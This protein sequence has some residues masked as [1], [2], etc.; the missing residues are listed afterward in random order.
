MTYRYLPHTSDIRVAI[1]GS[2]MA[3]V[4]TEA[5]RL[6]RE[7]LVGQ[8]PVRAEQ[9]R[10]IDVGAEEPA[11]LLLRFFR[12]CLY[13]FAVERFVPAAL[14]LAHLSERAICGTIHGESFDPVRHDTQPEVKAVTRHHLSLTCRS[15]GWR[16]EVVF[17]L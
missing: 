1:T 10:S 15:N 9:A 13:L 2:D 12:E 14:D 11:E 5:T 3:E 16:A 8:S 4:F 7:L 17:D 6:V